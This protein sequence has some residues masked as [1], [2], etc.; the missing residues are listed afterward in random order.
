M[1]PDLLVVAVV[2]VLIRGS[3]RCG[4]FVP[5]PRLTYK[6]GARYLCKTMHVCNKGSSVDALK[7]QLQSS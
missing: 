5:L 7:Q 4:E 3:N 6:T 2:T 1:E